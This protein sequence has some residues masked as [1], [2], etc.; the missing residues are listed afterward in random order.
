MLGSET[1]CQALYAE[2]KSPMPEQ[3]SYEKHHHCMYTAE[4]VEAAVTLSARYIADRQ[5]PDKAIDLLDEA[6]SRVR[7][8]AHA[9]RRD[10]LSA[11]RAV[12][13][14]VAPWLE[15]QQVLEAKDEAIKVRADEPHPL[16]TAFHPCLSDVQSR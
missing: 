14:S 16:R 12:S 8:A 13:D 3:D 4:A 6:G 5:L 7:I 15:L 11:G 1:N 10:A 2:R 9:A